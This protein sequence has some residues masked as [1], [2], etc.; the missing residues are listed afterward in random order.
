[1]NGG[2]GGARFY[3]GPLGELQAWAAA[4]TDLVFTQGMTGHDAQ[5]GH[6]VHNLAEVPAPLRDRVTSDMVIADVPDARIRAQTLVA[7]EH[8]RRALEAANS[9]LMR[10]VTL[11]LFLRDMRDSS[12]AAQVVKSVLGDNVPATT[13]VVATGV[14]VDPAVDVVLDAVAAPNDARFTLRHVRMP[15]LE[16]LTGGFPAATVYGPYVFTTPVS[17]ADSQSGR[18]VATRESLTQ[19]ERAL[20]DADY[21]NPRDEALAIEHVL[22]W[23][24]IH[25]ILAA[26]N[27]PFQNI[28]HQNNWLTVSMQHYVPVTR[29]RSRLFGRGDARTAATSLPITELRTPGA[30]FECSVT[31]IAPGQPADVRK[32]IKLGSHGVGPYY[33]GAV[34]AGPCVFAA[35]EVPVI[36]LPGQA[37]A[38]VA[39]AARLDD[40]LRHMNLGRV[41]AEFP[42]MAQ[43]HCVY[44]LIADALAR[45]GSS[46]QDVLHQTVYLVEPAHFPALERI[47]SLHFGVRL[48]PT[49]LVPI[50][51][52]SPFAG[53]LL[54]IE[55]TAH[56]GN[57]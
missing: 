24:N 15:E 16:T 36:A 30:A 17:G 51:G 1:M 54:E 43:A 13:I 52:A 44:K 31:G 2:T 32:E 14:G 26:T 40:G 18:I 5:S 23:R 55:V 34:K 4:G 29:V 57:D 27:V 6:L 22:M 8:V 21:F 56:A 19:D 45:H 41:H 12:A 50:R 7:L 39:A 35:G 49:T 47:A 28:V 37:P 10:L 46:L 42:L 9:S 38:L 33:V 11:R 53:T 20:I 48:P 25:R 3:A